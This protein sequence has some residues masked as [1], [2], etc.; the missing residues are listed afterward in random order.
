MDDVWHLPR[1]GAI[2]LVETV[3]GM[4][5]RQLVLV[6]TLSGGEPG[7]L[8]R[9]P[10]IVQERLGVGYRNLVVTRAVSRGKTHNGGS[11]S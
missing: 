9:E 3:C 4:V 7:I 6:Q 1:A 11:G 8:L 10:E 2:L 5:V